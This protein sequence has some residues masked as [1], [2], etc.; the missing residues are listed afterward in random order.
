M[1]RSA[2]GSEE[3]A[4][5]KRDVRERAKCEFGITTESVDA[6]VSEFVWIVVM[7]VHIGVEV[8]DD[9][10]R[11]RVTRIEAIVTTRDCG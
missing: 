6:C 2:A 9:V 4:G 11:D 5:R 1:R 3:L 10:V 8:D 7:D